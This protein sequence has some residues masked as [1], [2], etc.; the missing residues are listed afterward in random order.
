MKQ[1]IIDIIKSQSCKTENGEI[2]SFTSA[3]DIDEAEFISSLIQQYHP[4]RTIEIGC[5]EG[6]SSL[7]ILDSLSGWAAQHTIIDPYQSTQWKNVGL[8]LL[9]KFGYSILS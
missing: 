2:I 9:K 4:L 7:A 3:I 5:A 8:N 1:D 6:A